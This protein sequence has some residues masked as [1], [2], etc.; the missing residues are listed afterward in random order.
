MRKFAYAFLMAVT[1]SFPLISIAK[2]TD[3]QSA[4]LL[5]GVKILN[6][7]KKYELN[8]A[9]LGVSGAFIPTCPSIEITQD[10]KR[11][12]SQYNSD[13]GTG[14]QVSSLQAFLWQYKSQYSNWRFPALRKDF[15]TGYYGL[16]T[17]RVVQD[18]QD[19]IV[20]T[21]AQGEYGNV[22]AA[23]RQKIKEVCAPLI[24]P[25]P[26]LINGWVNS[27][28]TPYTAEVWYRDNFATNETGFALER[29]E[30]G[31]TTGFVL[32]ANLPPCLNTGGTQ[33][34]GSLYIDQTVQL[35]KTYYYRLKTLAAGGES[36][37]SRVLTMSI[38]APT[39]TALNVKPIY[40]VPKNRTP[41]PNWQE[42]TQTAISL[43]QDFYGKESESIGKGYRTFNVERDAV[44]KPKV[45][46]VRGSQDDT[47]Y[48]IDRGYLNVWNEVKTSFPTQESVDLI[49]ADT[50]TFDSSTQ[51]YQGIGSWGDDSGGSVYGGIASGDAIMHLLATTTQSQLKVFCDPALSAERW[52]VG[53]AIRTRGDMAS[54]RLGGLAHELGHAFGLEHPID[55]SSLMSSGFVNFRN[56][57]TT[58]GGTGLPKLSEEE[59]LLLNN[60]RAFKPSYESWDVTLPQVQIA[61]G[62]SLNNGTFSVPL[63]LSDAGGSGLTRILVL[64]NGVQIG[65]RDITTLGS[66]PTSYTFTYNGPYPYTYTGVSKLNIQVWD[67]A[68]N[69]NTLPVTFSALPASPCPASPVNA[70]C[71][72]YYNNKSL[73]PS[74]RTLTRTDSQINF[75]WGV[76]SPSFGIPSDGFSVRWKGLFDFGGN[77]KFTVTS[78]DGVR[79]WADGELIIDAWKIQDPTTYTIEKN[80]TGRKEIIVEYF[81]NT[82][83]ASISVGWEQ[84]EIATVPSA[85]QGDITPPVVTIVLPGSDT[86]TSKNSIVFSATATDNNGGNQGVKKVLWSTDRG[87]SGSAV[88]GYGWVA[89]IPLEIGSNV[90]TYSAYDAAGNIGTASRTIMRT[91]SA[92]KQSE[93]EN[94]FTRGGSVPMY[95]SLVGGVTSF[96]SHAKGGLDFVME[97]IH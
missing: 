11:D 1:I 82:S 37:Y 81:E 56:A 80:L 47:A 67:G 10:L 21:Y 79:V 60:N 94:R 91:T 49:L 89:T 78:D 29:S 5:H 17:Y 46:M 16:N 9:S 86:T 74:G 39:L 71:G 43:I 52:F 32:L 40:F 55:Q 25:T 75:N 61:S 90:V 96:L 45:Y 48:Q 66:G 2:N 26:T 57:F 15:V 13:T 68:Q 95:S 41:D 27:T 30:T 93:G 58:C 6:E 88:A 31:S 20:K 73:A 8:N 59:S 33:P 70:F 76:D 84:K 23:T 24:P 44:G 92:S 18:F 4:M 85:P 53:D 65:V 51:V 54:I 87:Y 42:K 77:T 34:C 38:A 7:A 12:G 22:F 19:T 69:K 63:T 83:G 97:N 3:V 14:G 72:E 35:N 36:V 64:L 28:S 50:S 62:V